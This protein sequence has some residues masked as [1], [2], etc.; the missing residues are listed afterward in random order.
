[1][2]RAKC[3]PDLSPAKVIFS[4][5]LLDRSIHFEP[6]N[7][8]VLLLLAEEVGMGGRAMPK[9]KVKRPSRMNIHAQPDFLPIPSIFTIPKAS[10]PE[11]APD[12]DAAEKKIDMLKG[13]Q[14][15]RSGQRQ[16]G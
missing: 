16:I 12:K 11:N 15:A 14:H 2:R 3:H 8:V 6:Q 10:R 13:C 1:V 4:F 7:Y 9:T 5:N